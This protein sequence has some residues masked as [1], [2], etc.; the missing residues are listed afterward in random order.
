MEQ[1]WAGN[2]RFPP[3]AVVR[4]TTEGE[5]RELVTAATDGGVTVRSVGSGHSFNPIAVAE[6]IVDTGGLPERFV[7]SEDRSTVTINGAMTYGRLARLLEQEG[8]ALHNLASLPHISVAGAVSTGTHGSGTGNGN[9]ATAVAALTLITAD[10]TSQAFRRGDP[11]F[12]GAVVSLGALGVVTTVTLDVVPAFQVAQRITLDV[13]LE[14]LAVDLETIFA[15]GYSVSAFTGWQATAEQLWF[16]YRAG[17]EPV[18][19]PG[20]PAETKL[21]PIAAIDPEPCTDQLGVPGSW[22]DRLPHFRMD[23]TPS[24]G[25]EIQTEYFVDL[26]DGAAAIR[27]M[28]RIGDRLK[29]VLLVSE[30]RTVAADDLWLSQSHGRPSLA[31]H[32]TWIPDV[33]AANAAA[34]TVA[35]ALSGL[36]PRPHWGKVFDPRQFDL[37]GFDRLDDFL[38]LMARTDPWRTFTNGWL[39][40]VFAGY[41]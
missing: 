31:L 28:S 23:F 32:F 38:G 40:E 5:L 1:N 27:A 18:T 12:A 4:P 17:Q 29:D 34:R 15:A 16:K 24:A 41:R 20:R 9:L 39:S 8:L 10:G 19:I 22:A 35:D 11:D 2:V 13:P 37:G 26:A 33:D 36:S 7:V 25:E 6:T 21:H 14:Q 3:G 30:L